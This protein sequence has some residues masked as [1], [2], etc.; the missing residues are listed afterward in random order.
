LM[1]NLSVLMRAED[2]SSAL[3]GCINV[4]RTQSGS[5]SEDSCF[6]LFSFSFS[7]SWSGS[8]SWTGR[9]LFPPERLGASCISTSQRSR[10]CR[11]KTRPTGQVKLKLLSNNW[12]VM[13]PQ[14]RAT[15][16]RIWSFRTHHFVLAHM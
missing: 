15:V 4:S 6:F 9:T 1:L 14:R 5:G 10:W 16:T 12:S 3:T 2:S 7:F 11:S 8:V 13:E